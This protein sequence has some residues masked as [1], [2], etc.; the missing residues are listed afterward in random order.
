MNIELQELIP[1]LE[2]Q[3]GKLVIENTKKDIVIN[4][5]ALKIQSLELALQEATA[6]ADNVETREETI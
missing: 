5:L 1:R 2:S 3:L 4:N 6:T